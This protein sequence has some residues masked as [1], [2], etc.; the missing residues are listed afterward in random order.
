MPSEQVQN[1]ARAA[2]DVGLAVW[3]GGTVFG[4]FAL[5]PAVKAIQ[6]ETARGQAANAGWA[7]FHPLGGVGLA[8]AAV[9]RFTARQTELQPVNLSP[10]EKVL[11]T[12]GDVLM[13][14]SLGLTLASGI[15]GQRLASK[16]SVPMESGTQPTAGTPPEVAKLQK[17]N[18]VLG[19]STVLAGLGLLTVQAIQDR[20]SFSRPSKKRLF[21]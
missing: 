16:G 15:Y 20:V 19:N 9:V 1:F 7:A 17:S 10:A 14:T 12:A 6:D 4:K 3:Y 5:N 21:R 13:V 2:H 11:A 8:T 18:E